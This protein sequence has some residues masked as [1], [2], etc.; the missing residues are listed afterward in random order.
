MGADTGVHVETDLR[1]DQDLQPLAVSKVFAALAKKFDP[2]LILLGKQSIDSDNGQ[3]AQMLSALLNWPL[4]TQASKITFSD[5]KKT[6]TVLREVDS[7]LQTVKFPVPGVVSTDLR[8]NEPRFATLPNIMKARK[9][10]LEIIPIASLG[11]DAQPHMKIVSVKE[12][13]QRKA[14]VKVESV[15][16]LADILKA[17]GFIN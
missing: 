4:A 8:L 13:P 11:V 7:G 15:Q 10:A 16:A 3:T 14:G 1:P 17:K 5:D 9:K 12:P 6:A 2:S